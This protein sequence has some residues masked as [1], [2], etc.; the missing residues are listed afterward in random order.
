MESD[1]DRWGVRHFRSSSADEFD[2]LRYSPSAHVMHH[3][4]SCDPYVVYRQYNPSD[5]N[6]SLESSPEPTARVVSL[7]VVCLFVVRCLLY[8]KW[9]KIHWAKL[10]QI[11]PNVAFNRK[12]SR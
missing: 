2:E 8:L 3:T 4:G 7:F 6:V 1:S 11:P 5:S 10:L 12:L 9:G